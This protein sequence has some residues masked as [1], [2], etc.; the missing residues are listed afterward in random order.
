MPLYELLS[1]ERVAI[2]VEPG[3]RN[4]VLETAARML[5]EG[6][7]LIAA[8]LNAGLREREKLASTA[9]GH[10]V[11]IPHGRSPLFETSRAVFL[12]LA[13]PVDF[14]APDGQPVDLVLAMAVPEHHVQQHLQLLAELAERFADPGFRDRLRSAPSVAELSFRLLDHCRRSAA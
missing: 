7:P 14:G 1:A 8:S 4:A 3:D 10:G 5:S 11:A 13:Q 12:R 9:I 2:L 6:S